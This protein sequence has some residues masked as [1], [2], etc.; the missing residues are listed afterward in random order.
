MFEVHDISPSRMRIRQSIRWEI[1]SAAGYLY[2]SWLESELFDCYLQ[3][4]AASIY[5][6]TIFLSFWRES[7]FMRISYRSNRRGITMEYWTVH[8]KIPR[9][10]LS[11]AKFLLIGSYHWQCIYL[12]YTAEQTFLRVHIDCEA[13]PIYHSHRYFKST[14]VRRIKKLLANSD[15]K[16]EWRPWKTLPKF[17]STHV[18]FLLCL[19][20]IQADEFFV[21]KLDERLTFPL[22]LCCAP[23]NR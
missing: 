23:K 10:S 12:A 15:S 5:L 18:P 22:T 2:W 4:W 9:N 6:I 14:F 16:T 11:T 8:V 19:L 3:V 21:I 7:G 17:D 20:F 1:P 13:I